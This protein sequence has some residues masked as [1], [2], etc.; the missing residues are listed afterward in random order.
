MLI[1]TELK[2]QCWRAVAVFEDRT[3][4]LLYL[5]RSSTQVKN[6]LR[7]AFF[8]VLDREER[9]GVKAISLQRWHGA[10]DAGRWI[11][12]MTLP[13][14]TGTPT[15]KIVVAEDVEDEMEEMLETA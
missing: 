9:S 14:P 12:Q 15:E 1:A 13:V 8:D 7:A 11:Q 6:G 3:E 5:N 4:Q 10:P 2:P